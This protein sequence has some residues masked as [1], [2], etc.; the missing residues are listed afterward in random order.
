[1]FEPSDDLTLMGD[2]FKPIPNLEEERKSF[3]A[4]FKND[5]DIID[6]EPITDSNGIDD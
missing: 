3:R 4:I 6:V 2:E 5:R 1:M